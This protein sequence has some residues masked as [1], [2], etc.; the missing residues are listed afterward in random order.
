LNN[1][2]KKQLEKKKEYMSP[3]SWD[4]YLTFDLKNYEIP[5]HMDT[6]LKQLSILFYITGGNISTSLYNNGDSLNYIKSKKVNEIEFRENRLFIFC[7]SIFD[8]T[9]HGV[10]KICNNKEKRITIQSHL[11]LINKPKIQW[12]SFGIGSIRY[13]YKKRQDEFS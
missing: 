5:P 6:P 4:V 9:W 12:H 1:I 11:N 13:K 8:R 7:P 10:E 2:F 3:S